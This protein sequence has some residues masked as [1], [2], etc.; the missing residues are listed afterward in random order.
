[1]SK[2]IFI[3]GASRGFGRVWAEAFLQRGDKVVATARKVETLDDLV[4][5]YGDNILPLQLDVTDRHADIE[6]VAK[7]VQLFGKIDVLINNAG[8]GL[9]GA[10]EEVSEQEARDQ[11]ETNVFGA[12]WLT[13][14]VLPVMRKQKSGH[15][16]QVSS[17]GGIASFPITGLYHASKW[18]LEGFSESL[19][20]EVGD[21]GIKVT[22]IEPAG[23]ETDWAGS[24]AIKSQPIE[25]Y[26]EIREARKQRFA[27]K[28]GDPKATAEAILKVINSDNPPLRLFLGTMPLP[29]AKQRYDERIKTW[30]EWK[31]VADAAQGN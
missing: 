25:A 6:A 18:A 26:D 10:I 2:V 27:G 30:E 1:M 24:S 9:F 8:Y 19:S 20:Q 31:D 28:R 4:D 17:I 29:L 3:T 16:L 23:Y 7:A 21:F 11:F 5:A 15:I 12:L 14:A 13:Q 22:L